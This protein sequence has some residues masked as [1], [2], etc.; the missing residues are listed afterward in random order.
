MK[1]SE[2]A[3]AT[4]SRL[5]GD[6]D[7]EIYSCASIEDAG[8][9]DITF[10]VN[11]KYLRYLGSTKAGAVI[12]D[13]A[14]ASSEFAQGKNLLLCTDP[15][16]VFSRAVE[17]FAPAPVSFAAGIHPSAAVSPDASVAASAHVGPLCIVESGAVVGERTV[18]VGAVYLGRN[19]SVGTDCM[20]HPG[21]V[22]N[23]RCV[24]GDRV[25]L[26]PNATIGSDGFGYSTVDG[27]H[28][29][30]PQLGNVV[31]ESDVEVGACSCIDRA[32]FASTVVGQGSKIDN[33]VQIAHNC[34]LGSHVI[35]AGQTGLSGSTRVGEYV[36]MAGQVGTNQHITIGERSVLLG[37]TGATKD[38]PPG[39]MVSGNP[40]MPH[41]EEL[42]FNA[43]LRK[44]PALLAKVSELEERIRHL[45]AQIADYRKKS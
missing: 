16:A 13:E 22:V 6:A 41:E 45:E 24:L 34:R 2:I 31:L 18:L 21:S 27:E 4:G 25:V 28:R 43:Q 44:V 15:N 10:L 38:I 35:I 19:T 26:Q 23:D 8:P 14:L 36:I 7:V 5:V 39:L 40:A 20:L 12:L 9:R 30:I 29:K 33:L 1:L 11:R 17:L 32:R 3:A 42:R 37:R